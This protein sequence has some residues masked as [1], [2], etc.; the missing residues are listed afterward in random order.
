MLSVMA[1]RLTHQIVLLCYQQVNI[2]YWIDSLDSLNTQLLDAI[3][4]FAG[5]LHLSLTKDTYECLGIQGKRSPF[6]N[7]LRFGTF[8]ILFSSFQCNYRYEKQ[9]IFT[10]FL[11]FLD[12]ELNL[13]APYFQPSKKYY[14]RV[15]KGFTKAGLKF[16]FLFSTL[17]KSH[18]KL[19]KKILK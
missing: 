13:L 3:I 16:K 12:I 7:K 17:S 8:F 6:N 14:E 18:G 10:F 1:Q 9:K 4:F 15:L 2:N 5:I 11:Y 19:V